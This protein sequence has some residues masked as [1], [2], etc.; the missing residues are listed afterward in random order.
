MAVCLTCWLMDSLLWML[1]KFCTSSNAPSAD[2]RP[3]NQARQDIVSQHSTPLER[4]GTESF[5][6]ESA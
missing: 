6:E 4:V 5:E 1:R 2:L 3:Q